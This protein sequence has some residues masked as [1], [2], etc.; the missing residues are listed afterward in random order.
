MAVRAANVSA[1]LFDLIEPAG[2]QS[3]LAAHIGFRLTARPAIVDL[4]FDYGRVS[5][6]SKLAASARG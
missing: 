2:R 5:S 3:H 1:R 4:A 6:S